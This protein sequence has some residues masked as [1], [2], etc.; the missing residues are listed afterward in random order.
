ML[1]RLLFALIIGAISVQVSAQSQ[2][3]G[4]PTPTEEMIKEYQTSFEK[5]KTYRP[6]SASEAI[7]AVEDFNK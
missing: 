1:I 3:L 7:A 2:E 5:Y 4:A 6:T